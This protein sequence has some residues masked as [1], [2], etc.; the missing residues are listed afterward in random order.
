[1]L[2]SP[3]LFLPGVGNFWKTTMASEYDQFNKIINI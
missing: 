1:M 2:G 3:G